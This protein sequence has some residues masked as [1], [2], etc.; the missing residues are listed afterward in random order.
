MLREN[1]ERGHGFIP[2]VILVALLVMFALLAWAI[3][4]IDFP[5]GDR[6]AVTHPLYPSM[7]RGS[8]TPGVR[9]FWIGLGLGLAQ[10]SFFTALLVLAL[11]GSRVRRTWIPLLGGGLAYGAVMSLLFLSYHSYSGSTESAFWW[12]FPAPTAW[13]VYGIWGVPWVFVAYFVYSFHRSY[14]RNEDLA[15]FERLLKKRSRPEVK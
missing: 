7:E 15:R 8:Q 4:S 11:P 14:L 6:S 12:G 13:L 5:P 1:S 9:L 3:V 10:V 2:A